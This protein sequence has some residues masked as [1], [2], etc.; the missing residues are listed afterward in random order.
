M[1]DFIDALL[2]PRTVFRG[3]APRP[4][5]SLAPIVGRDRLGVA[6]SIRF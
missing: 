4:R 3:G 6:A 1:H 2:G 5:V